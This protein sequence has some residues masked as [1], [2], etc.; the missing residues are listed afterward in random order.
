M[1][2]RILNLNALAETLVGIRIILMHIIVSMNKERAESAL[3]AGRWLETDLFVHLAHVA[4]P[5]VAHV[6]AKNNLL[7]RPAVISGTTFI[8]LKKIIVA[9]VL[10]VR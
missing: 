8:Q 4:L 5:I 7:V 1:Y 10:Q 2:S 6:A 3:P 9:D